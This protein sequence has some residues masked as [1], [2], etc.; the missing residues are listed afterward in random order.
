[1]LEV[2]IVRWHNFPW[3]WTFSHSLFF[4]LNF[5]LLLVHWPSLYLSEIMLNFCNQIECYANS[6]LNTWNYPANGIQTIVKYVVCIALPFTSHFKVPT[7]TRWTQK[8]NGNSLKSVSK[9]RRV[10]KKEWM[11]EC[12]TY[13]LRVCITRAYTHIAPVYKRWQPNTT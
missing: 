8:I 7:R 10:R 2:F 13:D 9:C 12:S 6:R 3:Y 4:H 5:L 11:N 1:M